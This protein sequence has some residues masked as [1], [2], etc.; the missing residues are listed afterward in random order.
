MP[1][2]PTPGRGDLWEPHQGPF[3]DKTAHEPTYGAS[4]LILNPVQRTQ[5]EFHM[6]SHFAIPISEEHAELAMLQDRDDWPSR[7]RKALLIG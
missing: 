6:Y 2:L 4:P 7:V 5:A 3:L 1:A